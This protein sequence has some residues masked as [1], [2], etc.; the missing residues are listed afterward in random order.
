MDGTH[1]DMKINDLAASNA[2]ESESDD[3]S[4]NEDLNILPSSMS[5]TWLEQQLGSG[6]R[7]LDILRRLVP[8]VP[9]DLQGVDDSR[10]LEILITLISRHEYRSP[11]TKLPQY[12]SFDDAVSL[13]RS[14][15][16][17]MVLTGAGISVSCGIPDFRSSNGIYAHVQKD[18]PDLRTPTQMFDID[19]FRYNPRPF[20][21]FVK[22][23]WPG[24][25]EPSITHKFIRKLE[26]EDI[27]LRQ[28]TQNIDALETIAQIRK[29]V[30]CHGNF[31]TATCTN[32][33]CRDKVTSE[34]I[35][36]KVMLKEIPSC[37]KCAAGLYKP[38]IVFFGED[39]PS[40][41]YESIKND[42]ADADLLI[43]IGSS[44]KV[45]P[46]SQIPHQIPPNI[47]QILIN[48]EPLSN[49]A[50][51]IELLGYCD[52]ITAEISTRLEWSLESSQ[53]RPKLL[54]QVTVRPSENIAS[55]LK[56]ISDGTESQNLPE[57]G[58]SSNAGQNA[59]M[60]SADN[61][62]QDP[63][64]IEKSKSV[65]HLL[66]SSEQFEQPKEIRKSFYNDILADHYVHVQ[67]SVT[68]FSGADLPLG[69]ISP[70]MNSEPMP[71][72]D[73]LNEDEG[74]VFG[75]H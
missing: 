66:C 62:E 44:L 21:A 59:N 65:P 43:V 3:S 4:D 15:K 25:F 52:T 12:S 35:R 31:A 2:I 29:T 54:K 18:F 8:D 10:I 53:G 26:E 67:P 50:F 72:S 37:K 45:S 55:V 46:V 36:E 40:E 23:L 30:F 60:G 28:Y 49:F 57:P 63:A 38:D 41:F 33:T 27:L 13:I 20:F 39:L 32:H 6:Q 71:S 14:S 48:R 74:M 16:K 68:Y 47:P 7:M 42:H 34:C 17:I 73:T 24:N 11:R 56:N 19:Y 51:D 5:F 1:S 9:E 22:E 64:H 70:D 58:A 69:D 75:A 61:I